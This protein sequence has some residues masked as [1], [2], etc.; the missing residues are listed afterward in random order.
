M[1]EITLRS[2]ARPTITSVASSNTDVALIGTNLAR[3]A[4]IFQN[5]S[6]SVLF[7]SLGTTASTAT[8][9]HSIQLASNASY[10]IEGYT[11][12]ARGIWTAANGQCNIT[13]LE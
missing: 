6:T 13:E 10:A 9:G 7:I 4:I 11:G 1:A 12:P 2:F 8:S 3:K 5:T